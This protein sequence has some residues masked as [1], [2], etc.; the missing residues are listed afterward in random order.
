MNREINCQ[1]CRKPLSDK[2]F[3]TRGMTT[4]PSC[5][6]PVHVDAFPAFFQSATPG[7]AGETL[8][9]DDEASCFYHSQKKAVVHCQQCGRFLCGLCDLEL[10][11]QHLCAACVESG[12]KKGKINTLEN[13][14]TLYDS[15]ALRLA[16]Y[17][18]ITF[19]LTL[20]GAIASIIVAIK[21]WNAPTSI[22]PRTKVRFVFAILIAIL[23]LA[24]W[25][26]ALWAFFM[27]VLPEI[28]K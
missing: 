24:G 20:P 9:T 18:I 13:H 25:G 10:N 8:F 7:N 21:Y 4:C 15:I 5:D 17:P 16:F 11:G 1:K 26:A 2:Q 23:E 14:R 12:K 19:Y 22:L 3:N 27:Y 6:T 28:A